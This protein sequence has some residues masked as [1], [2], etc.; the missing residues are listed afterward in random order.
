MFGPRELYEEYKEG[1]KLLKSAVL[2]MSLGLAAMSTGAGLEMADGVEVNGHHIL[3]AGFGTIGALA[4][5]GGLVLLG[6]QQLLHRDARNE[7]NNNT[8]NGNQI[9]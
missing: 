6:G 4:I 5:G 9:N 1:T 7:R 8:E 2:T 3:D